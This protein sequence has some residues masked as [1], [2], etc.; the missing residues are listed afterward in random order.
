M[1][2]I[3]NLHSSFSSIDTTWKNKTPIIST[4]TVTIVTNLSKTFVQFQSIFI[5]STQIQMT[6]VLRMHWSMEKKLL[7]S[8]SSSKTFTQTQKLYK[9]TYI[10]CNPLR[11]LFIHPF[12][13]NLLAPRGTLGLKCICRA[14]LITQTTHLHCRWPYNYVRSFLAYCRG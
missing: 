13:T 8:K 5:V 2:K 12:D 7:I 4:E 6:F 11:S 3:L 10:F 9:I 14:Q 1:R